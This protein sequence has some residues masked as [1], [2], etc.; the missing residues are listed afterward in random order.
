MIP[1]HLANWLVDHPRV[2]KLLG[3]KDFLALL[4]KIQETILS[5]EEQEL[6]GYNIIDADLDDKVLYD[7]FKK[8]RW[9]HEG[10]TSLLDTIKESLEVYENIS[11]SRIEPIIK[12]SPDRKRRSG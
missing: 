1:N 6:K 8:M 2:Y 9:I 3:D 4:E 12:T 5:P 11:R 7:N 10:K